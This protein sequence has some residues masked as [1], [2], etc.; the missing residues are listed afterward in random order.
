MQHSKKRIL[1]FAKFCKQG[2]KAA[3]NTIGNVFLVSSMMIPLSVAFCPRI[4]GRDLEKRLEIHD[5]VKIHWRQTLRVRV[6][7]RSARSVSLHSSVEYNAFF[8]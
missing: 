2:A 7:A 4:F 1:E 6:R 5:D 3:C 8:E